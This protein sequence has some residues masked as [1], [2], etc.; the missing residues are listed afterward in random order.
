MIRLP[1]PLANREMQIA[2]AAD[3]SRVDLR[4]E[5][6]SENAIELYLAGQTVRGEV[7]FRLADLLARFS[8][9]RSDLRRATSAANLSL[10]SIN[11]GK[12]AGAKRHQ[13]RALRIW[14]NAPD[15]IAAMKIAPRTR[16]SLFHLRIELKH[17]NTFHDNLRSRY[18]RFAT[19][20]EE[21]LR[22]LTTDTP[23]P[24]RHYARW[25]GE[26]P[27]VH[28][29]TR[30][31]MGACLLILDRDRQYSSKLK[32]SSHEV[33]GGITFGSGGVS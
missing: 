19:E 5:R 9:P 31:I 20:T 8:F 28:D 26:R 18:A 33:C 24:H 25:R 21:T 7:F 6:L 13:L 2:R 12:I 15:R 23:A 3:W 4:W 30:K 16:S 32:D 10:I 11:K 27:S 14:Q 1:Y 29:D 22:S 17:R